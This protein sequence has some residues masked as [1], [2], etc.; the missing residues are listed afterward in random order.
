MNSLLDVVR[1]AYLER[2]TGTIALDVGDEQP[3]LHVRE[4][5]V[6]LERSHELSM[7]LTERLKDDTVRARPAADPIL[8]SMG[9]DIARTLI[10]RVRKLPSAE[11]DPLA[12][13]AVFRPV[14]PDESGLVGPVPMVSVVLALAVEGWDEDT[15]LRHLGGKAARYVA[16]H[17]TPALA[18]LP[19]LA[20][21]MTRVVALVQDPTR[22]GAIQR[23]AGLDPADALRGLAQLQAVG[24][25]RRVGAGGTAIGEE[26]AAVAS[27]SG[28]SPSGG[29][30]LA[31]RKT[32]GGGAS[33]S[34]VQGFLD[35]IADDLIDEPLRID[36]NAHRHRIA[37]RLRRIGDDNHYRWLDLPPGAP[38]ERVHT[39]FR[40]VA[41]LVHPRHADALGFGGQ[42]ETFHVL[43]ERAAEAYIT[44]SNPELRLQYNADH[45]IQIKQ[46][47]ATEQRAAEKKRVAREQY[48]QAANAL[49]NAD[50]SAAV[51]LLKESTRLDPQPESLLLLAKTQGRNP[52]WY[53]HAVTNFERA[54]E[55]KP[56]DPAI[57]VEYGRQ[58]EVMGMRDA[59]RAQY[60]AA[61][62]AQP[63]HADASLAL[64][65]IDRSG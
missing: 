62:A 65:R 24:L 8:D 60:K 27:K 64:S 19:G 59:A 55:M 32:D 28:A 46:N 52:S 34:S 14:L 16:D 17:D 1:T 7:F 18:Q 35:R 54:I 38:P 53:R 9:T 2:Q 42:D 3:V 33:R 25:A 58:L 44:L 26:R 63:G 21:E 12:P 37:E 45:G 50:Y 22:V 29:G 57:R 48:L 43:F 51:D 10:E 40:D 4:G 30:V 49:N 11:G 6:Y 41:R 23:G 5:E 13:V 31:Q 36:A 20:P 47:I 39:A 56:Q 61:L 15:L